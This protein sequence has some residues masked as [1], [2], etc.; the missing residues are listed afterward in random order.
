MIYPISA[1]DAYMLWAE[2]QKETWP[3]GECKHE[4]CRQPIYFTGGTWYH[5]DGMRKCKTGESRTVAMPIRR[6]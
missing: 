3:I 6:P 1:T 4:H 5:Q 2:A